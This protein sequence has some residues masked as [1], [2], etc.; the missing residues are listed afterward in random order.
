MLE[1]EE[2]GQRAGHAAE[3]RVR[4]DVLDELALE[5]DIPG[6]PEAVQE[7]PARANAHRVAPC[8]VTLG[9]L[10]SPCAT[11]KCEAG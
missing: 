1:V 6:V 7:L 9:L 5:P 10:G 2:V 3:L 4:G 11:T 8:I